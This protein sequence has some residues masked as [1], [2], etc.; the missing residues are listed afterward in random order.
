[1][2]ADALIT[3]VLIVIFVAWFYG[4]WQ[5]SCADYARQVVFEQ[6]DILFDMASNGRINFKSREY[7]ETRGELNAVIRFAHRMTLGRMLFFVFCEK[8]GIINAPEINH[9]QIISK[10][11]TINKEISEIMTNSFKA[12]IVSMAARSLVFILL[13]VFVSPIIALSAYLYY[14][15]VGIKEATRAFSE[16]IIG[17]MVRFLKIEAFYET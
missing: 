12:I 14:L 15:I 5:E 6:R 16:S 1:M 9:T 8:I 3:L 17:P 2:N 11:D 4:P 7:N 10:D 13:C